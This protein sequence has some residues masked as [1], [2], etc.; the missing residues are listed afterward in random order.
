MIAKKDKDNPDSADKVAG[1]QPISQLSRF[2]GDLN[3]LIKY[4]TKPAVSGVQNIKIE[5]KD[6]E[7]QGW[8]V[9]YVPAGPNPPYRAEIELNNNFYKRAGSIF[10]PME[11]YDIRDVIFRF[12]Y[13]KIQLNL[14]LSVQDRPPSAPSDYLYSLAVDLENA[15][16]SALQ[17]YKI[18]VRIPMIT[19][20]IIHKHPNAVVEVG[21]DGEE[22]QIWK[23]HFSSLKDRS[24]TIFPGEKHRIIGPGKMDNICFTTSNRLQVENLI[25][26]TLRGITRDPMVVCRLLGTNIPPIEKSAALIELDIA[27]DRTE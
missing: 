22:L 4:A 11:P 15:G 12:Q 26:R 7:D 1:L 20:L 14:S 17:E 18:E 2:V 9:T 6:S 19:G 16:P 23:Y 27:I 13:P 5:P 3:N 24:V 21:M 8:V 25:L 10:Y